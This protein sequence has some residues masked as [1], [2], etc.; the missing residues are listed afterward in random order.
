MSLSGI[1][2]HHVQI[3]IRYTRLLQAGVPDNNWQERA[4]RSSI[5]RP[6]QAVTLSPA[7]FLN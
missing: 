6:Y 7:Q 2:F 5:H 3:A 4:V 1:T